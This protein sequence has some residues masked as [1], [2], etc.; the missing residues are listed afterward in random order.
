VFVLL[1]AGLGVIAFGL[2]IFR[3][4]EAYAKRSGRLKRSG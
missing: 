1:G 4:V 2:F 3:Y